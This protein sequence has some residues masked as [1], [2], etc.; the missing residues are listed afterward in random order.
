MTS[1]RLSWLASISRGPC[2]P[3]DAA[4]DIPG[5]GS[6]GFHLVWLDASEVRESFEAEIG[7]EVYSCFVPGDHKIAQLEVAMVLYALAARAQS[8]HDRRGF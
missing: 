3:F 1:P 6:G 8:F 4:E 2:S 7:P 5:R